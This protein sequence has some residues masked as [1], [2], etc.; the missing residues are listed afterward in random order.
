LITL[1]DTKYINMSRFV[2]RVVI[3]LVRKAWNENFTI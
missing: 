1:L 2:Q 3:P